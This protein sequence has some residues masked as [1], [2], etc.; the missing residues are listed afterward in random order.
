MKS[1]GLTMVGKL[2]IQIVENL[3]TFDTTDKGRLVY[4]NSEDKFYVGQSTAWDELP[5]VAEADSRYLLE[6]NNL[7]DINDS[8]IARQNLGVEIGVDVASYVKHNFTASSTPTSADDETAGYQSGSVWIN[9]TSTP[10][11]AYR[12][13]DATTDNAIWVNT[14]LEI[15]ELGTL[16]NQD[17]NNVSIT[18]GSISGI[19]DLAVADGGTGAS[20]PSAARNNLGLK[21]MATQAADNVNI[22]GGSVSG[23]TDLAIADGGTGASDASTARTNLGLENQ[24]T[25]TY[26]IS[27]VAP[28]SSDSGSDG[29]VWYVVTS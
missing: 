4:V 29:D 20:S 13:V 23:I 7:S 1:H 28:T 24:A 25:T 12:C 22:T 2:K 8:A 19:S 17:A 16:A 11:E 18:G 21:T 6:S 9:Q 14:S 26:N 3:P 5:V 15:G 10:P 27:T